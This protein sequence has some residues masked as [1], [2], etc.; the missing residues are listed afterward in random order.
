VS[1]FASAS[2]QL[3]GAEPQYTQIRFLP[4]KQ[5]RWLNDLDESQKRH[6]VVLGDEMTHHLFPGRPAI[7]SFILINGYRFEVIGTLQ[8]VGR[9]DENLTNTRLYPLPG[10]AQRFSAQGRRIL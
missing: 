3:N 7:G 2:G 5:G 10:D 1:E 8:R 4:L 6:V 9:G